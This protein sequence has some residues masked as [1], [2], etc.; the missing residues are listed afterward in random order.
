MVSTMTCI[1][2]E[3][4]RHIALVSMSYLTDFVAFGPSSTVITLYILPTYALHTMYIV[5]VP[6]HLI[7]FLFDIIVFI[8]SCN[9]EEVIRHLIIWRAPHSLHHED[10]LYSNIEATFTCIIVV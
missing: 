7:E 8:N 2:L 9:R 6:I 10:K 1:V 4:W 5:F 3:Q